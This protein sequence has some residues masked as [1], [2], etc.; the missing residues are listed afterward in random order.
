MLKCI[1]IC[2]VCQEKALKKIKRTAFAYQWEA[3]EKHVRYW[4]KFVVCI[5]L[6]E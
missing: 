6:D 2:S 5:G 1:W 3:Q 4:N